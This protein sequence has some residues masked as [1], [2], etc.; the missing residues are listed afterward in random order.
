MRWSAATHCE[1]ATVSPRGGVRALGGTGTPL[2]NA[3]IQ[4]ARATALRESMRDDVPAL[5]CNRLLDSASFSTPPRHRCRAFISVANLT[6]VVR[7]RQLTAMHGR[8]GSAAASEHSEEFVRG[9]LTPAI[10]RRGNGHKRKFK[11]C[12]ARARLHRNVRRSLVSLEH[13]YTCLKH[14]VISLSS[15]SKN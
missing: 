14:F 3:P 13:F 5:R 4:G 2:S 11:N 10:S 9:C 15:V 7:A 1:E 8:P 6:Q 12:A